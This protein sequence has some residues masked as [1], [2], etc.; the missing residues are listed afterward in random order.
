M[1]M[2]IG[3]M[4]KAVLVALVTVLIVSIVL[5]AYDMHIPGFYLLYGAVGVGFFIVAMTVLS[6]IQKE[7]KQ[8]D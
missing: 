4:L 5:I 7:G 3:V 1:T 2:N 6:V 8:D